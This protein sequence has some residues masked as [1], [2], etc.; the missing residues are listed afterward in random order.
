MMFFPML[1]IVGIFINSANFMH[2]KETMLM[3]S[4]LISF[5]T[6]ILKE[7][8]AQMRKFMLNNSRIDQGFSP[9]VIHF[10]LKPGVF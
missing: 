2:T 8:I 3:S 10:F 9:L 4:F 6:I 7:I 1:S 5:L